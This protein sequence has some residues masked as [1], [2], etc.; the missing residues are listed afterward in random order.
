MCQWGREAEHTPLP[1]P[2][3]ASPLYLSLPSHFLLPLP[4]NCPT[5]PTVFMFA[6]HYK[7]F[8]FKIKA[9]AYITHTC[10]CQCSPR[11][12][13]RR[14]VVQ[15][16]KKISALP[17]F[18]WCCNSRQAVLLLNSFVASSSRRYQIFKKICK[19]KFTMQLVKRQN[20][21]IVKFACV[22]YVVFPPGLIII[23]RDY[24]PDSVL[25]S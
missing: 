8:D 22:G 20:N 6:V 16:L 2:S 5:P 14:V 4:T 17:H 13:G 18:L 9:S 23:P 11:G 7:L 12:V 10:L 1:A 15:G 3:P 25:S 21:G 24:N 19:I